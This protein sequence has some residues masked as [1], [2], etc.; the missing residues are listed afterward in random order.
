MQ[1]AIINGQRDKIDKTK[2]ILLL[3]WF[4]RGFQIDSSILKSAMQSWKRGN[5]HN[6][7]LKIINNLHNSLLIWNIYITC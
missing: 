5:L 4:V 7:I 6:K 1:N 2:L 3:R